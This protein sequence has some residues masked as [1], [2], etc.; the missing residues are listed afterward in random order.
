MG[1]ESAFWG[2]PSI[3][4]A[5]VFNASYKPEGESITDIGDWGTSALR[6]SQ[7]PACQG[8]RVVITWR[9]HCMTGSDSQPGRP[10]NFV[11]SVLSEG[12]SILGLI[13]ISSHSESDML[14]ETGVL[15]S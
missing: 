6:D 12:V 15:M 13:R 8:L 2:E 3:C 9:G 1:K 5:E 4:Q 11:V 14:P 10:R 7:L